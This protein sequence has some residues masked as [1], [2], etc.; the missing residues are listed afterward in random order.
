[1]ALI[2]QQFN[3]KLTTKD[4]LV[5]LE[6]KLEK[7]LASKKDLEKFATKKDLEKF[8]TKEELKKEVSKLATKEEIK[9]DFEMFSIRAF[10]MF[11]TKEDLKELRQDIASDVN[12]KFD[13]I[14]TAVDGITKKYQE[15]DIGFVL[16][17]GAHDRFEEKLL[18]QKK[19]LELLKKI[20]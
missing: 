18:K 15:V 4:D 5:E 1:M 19:E 6:K 14:L 12:K 8:V 2:S 3:K 17:Q 9:K 7:K 16:N 13:K 20:K 11:A 10:E